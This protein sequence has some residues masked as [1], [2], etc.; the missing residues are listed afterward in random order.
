MLVFSYNLIYII[1]YENVVLAT[2]TRTCL[3]YML[4]VT[5]NNL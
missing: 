5:V 4:D 2:Y 1:W 3:L